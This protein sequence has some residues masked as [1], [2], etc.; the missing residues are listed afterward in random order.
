MKKAILTEGKIE[1]DPVCLYDGNYLHSQF[2]RK[3]GNKIPTLHI[4]N[5][6]HIQHPHY[7]VLFYDKST[8]N[9]FVHW[10]VYNIHI[11]DLRDVVDNQF[12]MSNNYPTMHNDFGSPGY[13]GPQPPSGVH[14]YVFQPI[15][16]ETEIT[17]QE[18][19]DVMHL[20]QKETYERIMALFKNRDNVEFIEPTE[21][22][23]DSK[24]HG[25]PNV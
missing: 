25:E 21:V 10:F 7:A 24:N 5:K 20:H 12:F 9:N 23:Y 6:K 15:K 17:K 19:N 3:Y 4:Q 14:T 11:P 22:L 16:Y 8:P 2:A 18:V 1:V 13:G